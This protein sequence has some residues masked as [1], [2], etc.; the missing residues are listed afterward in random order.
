[1]S[2]RFSDPRWKAA[3][4][5]AAVFAL[6][7][8]VGIAIDRLGTGRAPERAAAAP[9][10]VEALAEALDLESDDR[11]RVREVVDSLENAIA[12]ASAEGPASLRAAAQEARQQ[13]EAA[14]PA[15]RRG[16]F[17]SWMEAITPG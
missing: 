2:E 13:L 15:D 12:R 17:R 9:L 6:G 4:A 10:T 5:T 16:R 3:L 14:L 1:M 11:A 8:I 7:V